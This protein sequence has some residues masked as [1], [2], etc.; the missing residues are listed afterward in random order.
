MNEFKIQAYFIALIILV[1]NDE[2]K[3]S[4][5]IMIFFFCLYQ[6][7][8]SWARILLRWTIIGQLSENPL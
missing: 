4:E 2:K 5:T 6:K 1:A 8:F 3:A 7:C